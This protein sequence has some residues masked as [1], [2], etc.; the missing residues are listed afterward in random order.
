MS[1]L[2]ENK[3]VGIGR[4]K[5]LLPM[6]Q[7]ISEYQSCATLEALAFKYGC[8]VSTIHLRLR[9]AGVQTR[10]SSKKSLPVEEIISD[11]ESGMTAQT[12]GQKYGVS[13]STIRNRL[14]GAGVQNRKRSFG[15]GGNAGGW[16]QVHQ[17][18]DKS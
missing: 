14:I 16:A 2:K 1:C 13:T 12:L 6:E 9:K 8:S 4:K 10:P 11:Y 15:R 3:T 7:I 17:G 5:K 18:T